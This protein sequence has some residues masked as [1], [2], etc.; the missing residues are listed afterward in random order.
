MPLNGSGVLEGK[1]SQPHTAS[2]VQGP[3]ENSQ[4]RAPPGCPPTWVA[5]GHGVVVEFTGL[6]QDGDLIAGIGTNVIGNIIIVPIKEHAR[7]AADF[8]LFFL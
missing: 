7:K 6:E 4:P 2:L 8:L 3:R 5:E 1:G